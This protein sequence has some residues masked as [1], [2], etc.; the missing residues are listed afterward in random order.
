MNMSYFYSDVPPVLPPPPVCHPWR[1]HVSGVCGRRG[2]HVPV[3]QAGKHHAIHCLTQKVT[4]DTSWG[5]YYSVKSGMLLGISLIMTFHYLRSNFFIPSQ[6]FCW[7]LNF[8]LIIL[9]NFVKDHQFSY[10]WDSEK[11]T[12]IVTLISAQVNVIYF[13]YYLY[14]D[15]RGKFD[16][17]K[18]DESTEEFGS[19]WRGTICALMTKM[20]HWRVVTIYLRFDIDCTLHVSDFLEHVHKKNCCDIFYL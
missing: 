8:L 18:I 2:Q 11:T 13:Q 16:F 5:T 3:L 14:M 9:D 20:E 1:V 10:V 17:K 15:G 4:L 6:K 7:T 19:W 12:C